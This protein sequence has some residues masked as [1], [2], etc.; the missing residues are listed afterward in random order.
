MKLRG[1]MIRLGFALFFILFSS[2]VISEWTVDYK[3]IR[4]SDSEEIYLNSGQT[5]Y[6]GERTVEE[7]YR[8]TAGI[9]IEFRITEGSI[10][11]IQTEL[12][13]G[14]LDVDIFLVISANASYQE[15]SAFS[16][17]IGSSSEQL[18]I[19]SRII[20]PSFDRFLFTNFP[21]ADLVI[22]PV[23]GSGTISVHYTTLHPARELIYLCVITMILGVSFF[24]KS[25]F[26]LIR[27]E[28][29]KRDS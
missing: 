3:Y 5:E 1:K 26:N 2:Y 14:D 7:I 18:T 17:N 23:T 4:Y 28:K 21:H 13:S 27:S 6:T 10:I 8:P 29:P 12:I 9:S 19:E 11:D 22:I 20:A 15:L 24:I 16:M 25:T